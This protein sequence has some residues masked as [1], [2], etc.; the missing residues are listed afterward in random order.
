MTLKRKVES[1]VRLHPV[2]RVTNYYEATLSCGHTAIVSP[3]RGKP[4]KTAFCHKCAKES[5]EPLEVDDGS[6]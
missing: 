1:A 2:D 3:Y 6:Q 4:P 5:R